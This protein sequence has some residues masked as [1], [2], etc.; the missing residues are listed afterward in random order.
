MC[1]ATESTGATGAQSR[2]RV[3]E[4]AR[5]NGKWFVVSGQ[6]TFRE[7]HAWSSP[8]GLDARLAAFPDAQHDATMWANAYAVG[9]E[10][11]IS[12]WMLGCARP[13]EGRFHLRGPQEDRRIP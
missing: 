3:V 7:G 2:S 4:R 10:H 13:R 8:A 5:T 1:D 9:A 12:S 6:D 11:D